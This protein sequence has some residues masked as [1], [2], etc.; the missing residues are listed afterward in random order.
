MKKI[1]TIFWT[2]IY[3][4]LVIGMGLFVTG[5]KATRETA[6]CLPIYIAFGIVTLIVAVIKENIPEPT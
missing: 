6:L 4:I 5:I 1:I 3:L 2:A